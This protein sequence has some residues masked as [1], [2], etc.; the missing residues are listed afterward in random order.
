MGVLDELVNK[1]KKKNADKKL[2][3]YQQA[4]DED[5]MYMEW[6]ATVPMNEFQGVFH[7]EEHSINTEKS[8]FDRTAVFHTSNR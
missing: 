5:D 3:S 4:D 7:K 1:N 2:S 8:V 6:P